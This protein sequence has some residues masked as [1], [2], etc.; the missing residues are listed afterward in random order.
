MW[1]H[2][3]YS[4]INE[5]SVQSLYLTNALIEPHNDNNDAYNFLS[6]PYIVIINVI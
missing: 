4:N 3:F 5:E 1:L 6:N 2:A